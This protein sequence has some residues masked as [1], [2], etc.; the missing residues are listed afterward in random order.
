[1]TIVVKVLKMLG[2]EIKTEKDKP[3]A[4]A[5]AALGVWF[6]LVGA[7]VDKQFNRRS[8]AYGFMS[9]SVKRRKFRLSGRLG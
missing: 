5:F 2:W 8:L 1:M 7:M 9:K 6:D 4:P 3:M